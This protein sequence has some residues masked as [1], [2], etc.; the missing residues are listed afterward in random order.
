MATSYDKLLRSL[1]V[2]YRKEVFKMSIE[3]RMNEENLLA[4]ISGELDHH[5]AAAMRTELDEKISNLNPH[6]LM[7]DFSDVSF[8]DSSGIGFIMG[9]Y[10]LMKENGGVVEVVNTPRNINKVLKISGLDKIITIGRCKNE[11]N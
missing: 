7:L 10:K 8:M 11:D 4:K 5:T 2:E 6:K 3:I 1:D 9:R